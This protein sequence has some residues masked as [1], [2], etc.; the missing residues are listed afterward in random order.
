MLRFDS[1]GIDAAIARDNRRRNKGASPQ[2]HGETAPQR[3]QRMNPLARRLAGAVFL[4][5]A[6]IAAAET[7][8][9]QARSENGI[10]Y[11]TG[12]ITEDESRALRSQARSWPLTVIFSEGRAREYLADVHVSIKDQ[13][14][15]EL[16]DVTTEG[17][18]LQAKLPE[19]R[20]SVTA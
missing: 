15:K 8:L 9:P 14:G 20:Y 5:V 11:V 4:A 13:S 12:G 10:T 2:V 18:I 7:A 6:G 16:L 17:P 1:S 19:G 3:R